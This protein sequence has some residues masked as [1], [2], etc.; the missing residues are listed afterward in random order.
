MIA[1]FVIANFVGKLCDSASTSKNEGNG[2]AYVHLY[3]WQD[4]RNRREKDVL[5]DK[6]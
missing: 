6:A 3:N 4:D 2:G 1:N 5:E